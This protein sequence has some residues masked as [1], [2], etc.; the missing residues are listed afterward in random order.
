MSSTLPGDET[1]AAS[2]AGT[3]EGCVYV[4]EGGRLLL[5]T[6]PYRELACQEPSAGSVWGRYSNLGQGASTRMRSGGAD[7]CDPYATDPVIPD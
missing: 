5:I 6:A 4:D 1:K 3:P 2:T 7:L